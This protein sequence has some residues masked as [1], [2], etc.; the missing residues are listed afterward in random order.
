MK[1]KKK[2][3]EKSGGVL[4]K[5]LGR[6]SLPLVER[7]SSPLFLLVFLFLWSFSSSH[8]LLPQRLSGIKA[9]ISMSLALHVYNINM[10]L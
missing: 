2:L 3:K 7:T 6:L 9:R 8:M 10:L 5:K 4:P 1:I